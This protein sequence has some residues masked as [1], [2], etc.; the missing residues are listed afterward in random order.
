VSRVRTA[1]L[2]GRLGAAIPAGLSSSETAKAAGLAGAALGAN[3]LAL[4]FTIVF[5]RLLGAEDYG[6][7]AAL[8]STYIILSVPGSALLVAT[9]RETA[10]GRLG[11]GGAV[12][13][14]VAHWLRR[15]LLI[16]V[17]V[18]LVSALA[19]RPLASAIGVDQVWAAAAVPVTGCAW[20][21]LSV[22]RG[23]L[24]G[25]HAYRPVGLSILGEASGRVV[26]GLVLYGIGGAVTGAYLGTPVSMFVAAAVLVPVLWSR[27]G[28]SDHGP[29]RRRL[30]SLAVETWAPMV[31]LTLVAVL[32]NIDVI[33]VK[34][35]VGGDLAGSYAAISV[36]AKAI[37]WVAIGL[38]MHLV[39]DTAR[40]LREGEDPRQ[41]L[42]RA[43][44][45]VGVLAVPALLI[46][47]AVP[48][49]LIRVAFGSDLTEASGALFTLG[50]AMV[51]LACTY[52]AVQ[53][54]LA[55]GRRAF[56][57]ALAAGA[58][59]EPAVLL[60]SGVTDLET[61]A[62]LVLAVQ[63]A[64]AAATLLAA[65]R[66][67]VS[68]PGAPGPPQPAPRARPPRGDL[69]PRRAPGRARDPSG[70]GRPG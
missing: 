9:A 13:A 49:P 42:L 40:R 34:H 1:R 22:L 36:A 64:T 21:L 44:A 61:F 57:I 62:L 15:L 60:I 30:R 45:I 56:L 38:S 7:L 59:L 16:T 67:G 52:L 41:G 8:L 6:S 31:G 12:A 23:V 70:G 10:L 55:L 35:Q 69:R 20:V 17:G 58:V 24:Q 19:R 68:L 50:L 11:T 54:Q 37:I 29:E 48:E 18:A 26:F 32:Q 47:A 66:A 28:A 53:Y 43:L 4:V 63:A 2:R 5:A 65:V 51:L 27:T 33:I 39:P 14:T 25:L 3:V 46:F